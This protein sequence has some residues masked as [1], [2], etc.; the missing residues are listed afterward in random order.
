MADKKFGVKQLD[1]IGTG[2]PTIQSANNL[3]L[4]ATTTA[5]SNDVTV[6]GNLTVTGSIIGINEVSVKDFGAKGDGTTDDTAAIQ[7]AIDY[8]ETKVISTFRS[9]ATVYF[10]AGTYVVS[11]GLTIDTGNV[12]IAGDGISA[13]VIIADS[14]SFNVLSFDAGGSSVYRASVRDIRILAIGNATAGALLYMNRCLHSIVDSISLDGGFECLK[15]DGCNKLYINNILTHQT[16]RSSGTP[17]YQ[18]N[19]V[20]TAN[21][22][23]DVHVTNFQLFTQPSSRGN[24]S[25]SITGSDGIYFT[26][27]HQHGGVILQP[28]GTAPEDICASVTWS[29][30]YFDSSPEHHINFGGNATSYRNFRFTNCVF[31]DGN[32]GVHVSSTSNVE[33]V[34]FSGCQFQ[35]HSQPAINQSASGCKNWIIADTIFVDNTSTTGFISIEGENHLFNGLTFEGGNASG[36][37]ITLTSAT[38]KCLLSDISFRNCTSGTYISNLGTGNKLGSGLDGYTLKSTGT[39]TINNGSTSTNVTHNLSVTPSLANINVQ[40][41]ADASG[42]TRH[43]ITNPTSTQFTINTDA[44]PSTTA[45]FV[46]SVDATNV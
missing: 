23:S 30:V 40:L 41:S 9:G 3:N 36:T 2:T 15:A 39:A 24:Y 38:S 45:Q 6:G 27:G 42:V 21:R 18:L 20:S 35:T 19:F 32:S 34:I 16:S 25:V 11:S 37:A 33:R 31:R 46:W 43:Y 5:I 8:A 26:S 22:C 13:S 14:P 1:L 44:T 7:A 28:S 4:N 29:N 12:G 17:S 10:P